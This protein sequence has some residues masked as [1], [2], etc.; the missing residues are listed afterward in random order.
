MIKPLNSRF[1][2]Q[3]GKAT[4]MGTKSR[5]GG[6]VLAT[7]VGAIA[8][9]LLIAVLTK[10][11]PRMMSEMMSKMMGNMMAHMKERGFDPAEI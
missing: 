9:G 5:T 2:E 1:V 8:G 3:K 11:I 6:Y 7:L 4:K 10:A